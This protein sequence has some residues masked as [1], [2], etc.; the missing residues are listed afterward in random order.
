MI[1]ACLWRYVHLMDEVKGFYSFAA[2][3]RAFHQPR[4]WALGMA[5]ASL[6]FNSD[7]FTYGCSLT[8][9]SPWQYTQFSMMAATSTKPVRGWHREVVLS[10]GPT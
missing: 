10:R 3:S 1:L 4:C 6:P 9:S 7:T 8:P 5:W 2:F